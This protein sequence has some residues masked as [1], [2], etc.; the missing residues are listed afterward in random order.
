[1]R[2]RYRMRSLCHNEM[3]IRRMIRNAKDLSPD[4]RAVIETLLGRHVTEN[5]AISVRAIE[6]PSLSEQRRLEVLRRL[7][8]YFAQVD[9]QR[10]PVLPQEANTIIDEA[11]RS[12]RPNYR[13]IR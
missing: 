9:E 13:S 12:T 10:Q 7:E 3:M 1:M 11:L 5:E 4:Q 2:R 6:P 8:A